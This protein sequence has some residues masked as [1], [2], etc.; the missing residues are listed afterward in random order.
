DADVRRCAEWLAAEF[1]RIG[2]QTVEILETG[3]H[4]VVYAHYETDPDAPTV[5]CYGHYDVQPPD[6]IELWTTPPFEPTRKNGT[7]YARGASDDKG[8]A[9]M[10]VKAAEACIATEGLPLNVKFVVEGE[11]EVGSEHL[12]EFLE[13]HKERLAADIVLISDTALFAPGVPS[14]SAGLRGLAY[15]EVELTGPDR[16]LHSGVYGGAVENPLNALATMISDLHDADHRITVAGFYDN[17]RDL[18]PEEREAYKSLPFDEASWLGSIGLDSA[19]PEAGYS[20][21]EAKSARPTLDVNGIWGGYQGEGAKTVLPGK[22]AAKISC[23]LVPDQTP[24]EIYEK[25]RAHFEAHTPD[26]MTLKFTVLHGGMPVL[27]DT[28]SPAMQAASEALEGV[29][30]RPPVF[31]RE[32]GSIPIVADFKQILGLDSVLMGFG[33]NTDALH[34]PNEHFGLDRFHQGI[35]AVVRFFY[36]YSG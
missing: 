26:T 5:L 2:M 33:L 23:R 3:G 11:E 18:S 1:E 4:P 21:L 24:D 6:P 30:G 10:H 22:A 7:L 16:D 15:I 19:R 29:F 31:T 20:V 35:E 34:S 13:T 9:F 25:L 28:S 17:V 14:I 27:V 8:Q 36:A 32:G 12:G